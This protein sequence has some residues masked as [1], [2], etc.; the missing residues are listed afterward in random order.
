MANFIKGYICRSKATDKIYISTGSKPPKKEEDTGWY[1]YIPGF[2]IT[3]P[4]R[5][6]KRNFGFSIKPG[7]HKPIDISISERIG[8]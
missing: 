4:V 7:T 2:L 1:R 6:F 5:T 8:K 3:L